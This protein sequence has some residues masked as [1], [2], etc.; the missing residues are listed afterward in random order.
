CFPSFLRSSFHML[1]RHCCRNASA[2]TNPSQRSKRLKKG[3]INQPCPGLC[4]DHR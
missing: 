1:H 2:R 4:I 3:T